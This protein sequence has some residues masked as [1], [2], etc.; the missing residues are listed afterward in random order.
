[1]CFDSKLSCFYIIFE[2]YN[3]IVLFSQGGSLLPSYL[4]LV[5]EF[6]YISISLKNNNMIALKRP[7][8]KEDERF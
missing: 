1:M 4:L 2:D 6:I 5:E 7:A 3:C 8:I